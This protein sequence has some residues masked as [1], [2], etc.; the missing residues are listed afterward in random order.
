MSKMEANIWESSSDDEEVNVGVVRRRRNFR[1]RIN[2]NFVSLY[3]FNERF[4]MTS[5]KLEELLQLIGLG[6]VRVTN[7]SQPLSTKLQLCIALHWMGTGGQYHAV[8]DMHGVS[9]ASVCR[10]VHRV[11]REINS[12]VFPRYIKWPNNIMD[13]VNRFYN[14]AQFPNVIGCVDG[15]LINI[16]KPHEHEEQFI[17]RHGNHSLNCMVV[18]GPDHSFYYVSARWPG[19]VHDSRVLRNTNLYRR[20]QNGW[21]P[22]HN[23]VILGDSGYPLLEWLITPTDRNLEDEAVRRFNR[24]HKSTRR[25]VENSLGILK[26]KFPC[27]NFLRLQPIFASEVFKCCTALCN[28]SRIEGEIF[29]GN[30]REQVDLDHMNDVN[31][32]P[33]VDGQRRLREL[34]NVFR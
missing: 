23:A 12:T 7:R 11:V 26:E 1:Q 13:I 4:R 8:S 24:A 6:L 19:S 14:I 25:L 9:K 31:I 15:T 32:E 3:E 2:F 16:E 5:Q 33:A 28:F 10:V 18:S 27:L 34:M 20:M 22:I 21:R 30:N 17:N 29:V